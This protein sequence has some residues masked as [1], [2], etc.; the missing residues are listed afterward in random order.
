MDIN[1]ELTIIIIDYSLVTNFFTLLAKKDKSRNYIFITSSLKSYLS[2]LN[3][4]LDV[5]L[6]SK[7][8]EKKHI[9]PNQIN[10]ENTRE[11][12]LDLLSSN[13][14]ISLHF[15]LY[16]LI[17]RLIHNKEYIKINLITWNGSNVFGETM[18]QIKD[19]RHNVSTIFLEISNIKSKIFRDEVG[20]NAKSNLYHNIDLLDR[21]DVCFNEHDAWS[22]RFISEK[23]E[24]STIPQAKTTKNLKLWHFI[25]FI[26]L[27]SIGYPTFNK[28]AIKNKLISKFTNK[29]NI[30]TESCLPEKFIF[31]PL[32]VSTDTQIK[33]NSDIDNI[34]AIAL[35]LKK[36]I[37]P[38]VVKPH[39]AEPDIDYFI[40]SIS[41]NKERI[42]FSTENTYKL[43]K[44]SEKV[45][46]INSTVGLEAMIFEKP[47]EFYG[48]SIFNEFNKNRLISYIH[49]HL[50]KIDFFNVKINDFSKENIGRIY[51][52]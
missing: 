51:G 28:K 8:S 14:I 20:V 50:I 12:A 31:F 39:P 2:L 35:M 22:K 38:I 9:P 36:E 1:K 43:I 49:S 7:F 47:V 44:M 37:L 33:I 21:Y 24:T 52:E 6:I 5:Y 15:A 10:E 48:R 3:K 13:E 23:L 45:I 27:C 42:F 40:K 19:E 18:R 4:K 25:D 29:E 32:Q 16:S 26:F 11:K 46:T 17:T 34:S 30:I 41:D